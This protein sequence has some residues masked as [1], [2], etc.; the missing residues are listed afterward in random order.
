MKICIAPK[1][2]RDENKFNLYRCRASNECKLTHG[3]SRIL[4]EFWVLIDRNIFIHQ[5]LWTILMRASEIER[6]RGRGRK[7]N[8]NNNNWFVQQF[9]YKKFS[10]EQFPTPSL[11]IDN[12][13][14]MLFTCS[15]WMRKM[16]TKHTKKKTCSVSSWIKNN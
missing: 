3:L 14:F 15:Q 6:E 7:W 1:R 10:V 16:Y 11:R 2:V 8:T 5:I 12:E 9:S 13:N 4:K